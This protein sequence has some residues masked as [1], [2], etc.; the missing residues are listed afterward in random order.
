MV[1]PNHLVIVDGHAFR[2]VA[3]D[4]A[5]FSAL[6]HVQTDD[7]VTKPVQVTGNVRDLFSMG[8][9]TWGLTGRIAP[10]QINP[11]AIQAVPAQAPLTG[12]GST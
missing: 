6:R 10:H 9:D 7:G 8:L 2:V 11:A 5:R 4:E 12:T 1:E 3:V